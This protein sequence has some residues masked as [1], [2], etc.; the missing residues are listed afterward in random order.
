MVNI[1]DKFA[2][3]VIKRASSNA[4]HFEKVSYKEFKQSM[5]K[6]C[7]YISRT[8]YLNI[9]N[10]IKL[11]KRKTKNA[12]G[13]DFDPPFE[14]ELHPAE[15][16]TIPLGIK[17]KTKMGWFLFIASRSGCGKF[18]IQLD[19]TIPII[20]G[21]YYNCLK[22]E[23]N[24]I[25]QLTNDNKRGEIFKISKD[26]SFVQGIITIYGLDSD[27]KG[28]NIIREGAFGSTNKKNQ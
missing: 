5:I 13:Y 6:Y 7:P 16:I 4:A 3:W 23:G 12:A 24:I 9:Y 1:L 28:N 8:E 21:D 27:D 15:S 19:D 17:C 2:D 22:N 26:N 25:V 20:D 11:P 14:W 18:R 10:S